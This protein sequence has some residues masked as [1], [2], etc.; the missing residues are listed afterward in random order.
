MVW[1]PICKHCNGEFTA[2]ELVRHEY[3]RVIVVHCPDCGC[4]LGQ[5]NR[6]SEAPKTDHGPK[7][8]H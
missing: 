7:T 4:V 5:Y 2:D 6:H 3:E 1:M 8:H